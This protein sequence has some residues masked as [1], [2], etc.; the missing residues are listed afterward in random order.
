MKIGRD[1]KNRR[2]DSAPGHQSAPAKDSRTFQGRIVANPIPNP[3]L[4]E[5]MTVFGFP[6]AFFREEDSCYV[7]PR[8][9]LARTRFEQNGL[10]FTNG[11]IKPNKNP[12]SL[13]PAGSGNWWVNAV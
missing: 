8:E 4:G 6:L 9:N 7:L 5:R 2:F 3:I 11:R 12:P 10:R 13:F 1:G